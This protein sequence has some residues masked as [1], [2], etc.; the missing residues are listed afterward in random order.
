MAL[1]LQEP[2]LLPISIAE[3]IAYGRPYATPL[4]VEA[5]AR[6]A[7]AHD[8]IM[9]LPDGYDTQLGERGATLSG[10]KKQ[11][12]SIA[13]A[14]LKDAPIPVLDEPTSELHA[15]TEE[16]LLEALETLKRGRTTFIAHRL[17]TIRNADLIVVMHEGRIVETGS[18]H[19]LI[20]KGGYYSRSY[21]AQMHVQR[22]VV[23]IA[24]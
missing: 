8:F 14:L 10:G 7:K 16:L 11:R 2:F 13:R 1:V 15:H 4:L 20:G 19:Q 23:G 6:A 24:S 18:H 12:I 5:A 3:N 9:R 17:S 22:P 21:N